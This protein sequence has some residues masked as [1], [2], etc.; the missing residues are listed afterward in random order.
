M[1]NNIIK[2]NKNTKLVALKFLKK[3]NLKILFKDYYIDN[4]HKID[5]I[6]KDQ[7]NHQIILFFLQELTHAN[8]KKKFKQK[9]LTKKEITSS[10]IYELTTFFA[11]KYNIFENIRID[12]L[13]IYIHK[14]KA[15]IKHKKDILNLNFFKSYKILRFAE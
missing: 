8:Y 13:Q 6:T 3:K 5:Y 4:I 15:K 10:K 1:I 9:H 2:Y 12:L 11:N 14:N 7:D